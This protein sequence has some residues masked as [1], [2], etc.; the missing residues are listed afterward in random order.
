MLGDGK[1]VRRGALRSDHSQ[2]EVERA[3]GATCLRAIV[4]GPRILALAANRAQRCEAGEHPHRW[5]LRVARERRGRYPLG[6]QV[7]RLWLIKADGHRLRRQEHGRDSAVL[8]SGGTRFRRGAR[9]RSES[10]LVESWG[11]LVRNAPWPVPL[12]GRAPE[13]DDQSRRVRLIDWCVAAGVRGREG[14]DPAVAP[15]CAGGAVAIGQMLAASM[16]NRHQRNLWDI[17]VLLSAFDLLAVCR[18]PGEQ[19][20]SASAVAHR[21]GHCAS[22]MEPCQCNAQW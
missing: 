10:R 20:G 7:G 14:L 17:V 15:R 6:H 2:K 3:G 21:T 1:V 19:A 18:E 9:L 16:A 5:H 13:R 12:Q 8:G 11:Y 22:Q 4:R